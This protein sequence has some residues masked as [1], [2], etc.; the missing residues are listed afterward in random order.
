MVFTYGYLVFLHI[1]LVCSITKLNLSN[2]SYKMRTLHKSCGGR[3]IHWIIH[4][5][6]FYYLYLSTL[7]RK[8]SIPSLSLSSITISKWL[9]QRTRSSLSFFHTSKHTKTASWRGCRERSPNLESLQSRFTI[10]GRPSI[11][12]RS[13][14][15]IRKPRCIGSLP[16]PMAMGL[17]PCSIAMPTFNMFFCR[18]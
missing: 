4:I 5:H 1:S 15:R 3:R 2:F 8:R 9:Q 10:G 7:S 17:R 18:R 12:S 6:S 11:V 16:T 13:H 14:T